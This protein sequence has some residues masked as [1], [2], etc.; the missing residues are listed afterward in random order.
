VTKQAPKAY[1][2]CSNPFRPDYPG[3]YTLLKSA[4]LIA[5][6]DRATAPMK[7]G[8]WHASGG[9]EEAVNKTW[10][11][12][13]LHRQAQQAGIGIRKDNLRPA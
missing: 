2:A 8:L 13:I 4:P 10:L 9:E 12:A 3:F 1:L 11:I 6:N 5:Q 7:P